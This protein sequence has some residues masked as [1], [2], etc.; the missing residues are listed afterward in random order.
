MKP[1]L[2]DNTQD[3]ILDAM[4]YPEFRKALAESNCKKCGLCQSR[5][6]IV[7]DRGNPNAKVMIIGE[8]PGREEDAQGKPFVGRAGKLLDRLLNEIGFDTNKESLIVNVVKCRP[9]ENRAPRPEEAAACRPFLNKQI[10]FI[11]PK[12]ILLL[13]ATALKH[14]LPKNAKTPMA[15]LVGQF[16][17]HPAYP[18]CK[19]MVLFHPAYL[20]RDPRKVPLMQEHLKLFKRHW[21]AA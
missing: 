10:E 4:A 14:I 19:I 17:E 9:P 1:D 16:L 13:G 21:Q 3:S 12:F 7:V 11:K 18:G 20:L 6:H 2:S 15:S 5:T 8:A